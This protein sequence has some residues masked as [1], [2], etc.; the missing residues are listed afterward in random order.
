MRRAIAALSF[1][2]LAATPMIQYQPYLQPQNLVDIGNGRHLNLYCTGSG[3]PT[4]ILD[5]DQDDSTLAWR[6]VQPVIARHTRVCSYDAAGV[7]FS[8]PAPAPR[9]AD[10]FVG[11]LK[12]LLAR[13]NIVG[14]YVLV[15]NGFSGLTDRIFAARYSKDVAG[16]VLVDPLVPYRNRRLA[17]LAPALAPMLNQTGFIS[18]LRMCE[19]AA[20][21]HQLQAGSPAFKACMWPT[22]PDDATLPLKVHQTLQD[23]WRRPGAW[24]DLIYD[25]ESDNKSSEEVEAAQRDYGSMPLIVLTSDIRVDMKGMPLS[26][27]QLNRIAAAYQQW[28]RD[29][30][31]LSSQGTESV[32]PGST[33]NMPTDHPREVISAIDKVLQRARRR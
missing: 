29:I 18:S 14:P 15:G 6:F 21:S 31:S 22:G 33:N 5:T 24:G 12:T 2:L 28:H 25:A 19:K 20:A 13:A 17:A 27:A 1:L 16:T 30:A 23:Q 4:V 3:S 11:D 32:I 7:G 10:A 8:D 9:D 26:A